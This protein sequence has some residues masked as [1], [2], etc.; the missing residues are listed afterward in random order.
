MYYSFFPTSLARPTFL[1]VMNAMIAAIVTPSAQRNSEFHDEKYLQVQEKAADIQN[2]SRRPV[3]REPDWEVTSVCIRL[4]M[5]TPTVE[6]IWSAVW[7][8]APA[9]DCSSLQRGLVS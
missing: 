2:V 3:R 1:R 7:K 9:R 8:R 6:A 4:Q 5:Q